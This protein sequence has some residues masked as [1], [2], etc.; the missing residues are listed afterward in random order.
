MEGG[1]L[2][3]ATGVSR[4]HS[5]ADWSTRFPDTEKNAYQPFI[6]ISMTNRIYRPNQAQEMASL[7]TLPLPKICALSNYT[8][9][10]SSNAA[11]DSF[12]KLHVE[13]FPE[14]MEI[15]PNVMY[16]FEQY[17]TFSRDWSKAMEK[18]I[19][20]LINIQKI[21]EKED[22]IPIPTAFLKMRIARILNVN[23]ESNVALSPSDSNLQ[24]K[25]SSI[26]QASFRSVPF[27]VSLIG[28]SLSSLTS[29]LNFFIEEDGYINAFIAKHNSLSRKATHVTLLLQKVR[30][31]VQARMEIKFLEISVPIFVVEASPRTNSLRISFG[32]MEHGTK[33]PEIICRCTHISQWYTFIKVWIA[34]KQEAITLSSSQQITELPTV[35]NTEHIKVNPPR[36]QFYKFITLVGQLET[37]KIHVDLSPMNKYDLTVSRLVGSMSQTCL[38]ESGTSLLTIFEMQSSDFSSKC[39]GLLTGSLTTQQGIGARYTKHYPDGHQELPSFQTYL[40]VPQVRFTLRERHVR[41]LFNAD[42]TGAG[43]RFYD[44][45]IRGSTCHHHVFV[46]AMTDRTHLS[47]SPDIEQALVRLAVEVRKSMSSEKRKAYQKLEGYTHNTSTKNVLSAEQTIALQNIPHMLCRSFLPIGQ[48]KFSLRDVVLTL[49]E[50]SQ[51][52][53]SAALLWTS[54]GLTAQYAQCVDKN[55]SRK[56][57]ELTIHSWDIFRKSQDRKVSSIIGASGQNQFEMSTSQITGSPDVR[58]IFK[59]LSH[60]PWHGSPHVVDFEVI[61]RT[62]RS[63]TQR[64][65]WNNIESSGES[66]SIFRELEDIRSFH[67]SVETHFVPEIRVVG[68]ATFHIRTVLGWLGV[69]E[70]AIPRLLYIH[71]MDK[72]E[73]VLAI[74]YQHSCPVDVLKTEMTNIAKHIRVFTDESRI[75]TD[76]G[77][78]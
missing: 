35:N 64:Q 10:Y 7:V 6:D 43:F 33:K 48:L 65:K 53:D 16:F 17:D 73:H 50:L 36:K 40:T 70:D 18:R 75:P 22:M 25:K 23:K 34:K 61:N 60:E 51:G 56:I 27:R 57:L 13:F 21:T 11:I 29:S 55:I 37:A 62:V 5:E 44:E 54:R 49:G 78:V 45:N 30:V 72:M 4:H 15:S 76:N 71:L 41:D 68:D 12:G 20:S 47:V 77:R 31:E 58:F 69:N 28:P 39:E 74:A 1:S 32:A 46:D 52:Y 38:P 42:I 8:C 9:T 3:L 24:T 63:F 59:F 2:R 66:G 26:W 19:Q 14:N 67:A